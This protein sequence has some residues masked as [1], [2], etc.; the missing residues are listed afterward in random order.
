MAHTASYRRILHKM[1]YYNYQAG[2][3]VRHLNQEGGWNTHNR[4]CREFIIRAV[5]ILRPSKITVLGSGWLLEFP[6][7]EIAERADKL[8]LA[9]IVH[10]PEVINQT[11]GISN[12]ELL[13]SDLTGGLIEEVWEK[14]SGS[15]FSQRVRSVSEICIPGF[16]L[17][18]PG[19]VISLNLLTQLEILPVK[20]LQRKTSLSEESLEQF[21]IKVQEKHIEFLGRHNSILISDTAELL[22]D[23][24]GNKTERPTLKTT[25]PD[26]KLKEIGRASC[27]ER[28]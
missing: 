14:T 21:S 28:V 15:I 17:P 5:D 6:V 10:P 9:D 20:L 2:L 25:L 4:K 1:G 8:V 12:I 11:A 3:I 27:R 24:K 23:K 18:D 7:A 16:D 19:L 26:G 22:T 13:E